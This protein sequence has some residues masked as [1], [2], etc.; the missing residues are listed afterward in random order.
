ML[1]KLLY[2]SKSHCCICS[3]LLCMLWQCKMCFCHA[4]KAN[5][6]ELRE[7][8]RK[9]RLSEHSLSVEMGRHKQSW[10]ARELRL[11]SHCTESVCVCV[12]V[13]VREREREYRL[14]EHSLSV[15][16]GRHKEL[17]GQRAPTVFTAQ[18]VCVRKRE[19]ENRLIPTEDWDPEEMCSVLASPHRSD[20]DSI[21][22]KALLANET[23][24]ESHP[25]NML[26]LQLVHKTQLFAD[27]S[28]N[29]KPLLKKL[30]KI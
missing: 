30:T 21:R 27:Y 17:E 28:F 10:R 23:S 24:A 4:N 7:G 25:L 11:C 16:M 26:T 13:C 19:R 18:C 5:W 2:C 6:I 3:L 20:P 1:F 8:E 9:Y 29:P 12:C 14:S 15:E 22:Y